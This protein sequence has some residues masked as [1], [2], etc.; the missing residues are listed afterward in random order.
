MVQAAP[1]TNSASDVLEEERLQDP[2]NDRV[3]TDVK[4]PPSIPLNTRRVFAQ[5]AATANS[6]INLDLVKNY[7]FEGGKISKE[8]LLEIMRRVRP[9][10]SAEPNLLRI[11]GKVVIVG[12]I[13][14]QFYDLVA[15]LRKLNTRSAGKQKIL[16]L[17][18]YVD[19]GNYGPEVAAYLFSL[20][21]KH[22]NDIFLLRGNHESRD[23]T[24]AFNFREQV[25]M[26][27]DEDVYEEYMDTFDNLP[28]SGV[29]NGRYLAMHGGISHRL[30]S[31][32]AINKVE[33]RMEPPDDTLLADLLWADPAKGRS[34]F[35]MN[36]ED[37]GE[38]GISVYFG[39]A[40]LKTLL[41]KERLKA[42]VRAHQQKQTGY[43]FHT[44]D[45]PNEFPPCITVFSA[46]NYCASDNDAAV[47]ISDGDKVD[48]R[49]F[50]ERKDKP[51]VLPE[52]AD[53][54]SVMQPRLQSLILDSIYNI[55]KFTVSSASPGLRRTLSQTQSVDD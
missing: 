19:R 49:T 47:M 54:F 32:D 51:Y 15:M 50:T 27:Y 22:P 20:K 26:L 9:V 40:P 7:L 31:L 35:S 5:G 37:N 10:L 11:E 16:F 39:K 45:G 38:R 6:D 29:V 46:P 17:G 23:M 43:K 53:A 44:W 41:Q 34:A 14:G 48:V 24:E 28:I 12:D 33:R 3:M 18:D 52:R 13:H 2:L 1:A 36:Y 30:T 4:R 42:V 55:L 8:C 21:L 25:L